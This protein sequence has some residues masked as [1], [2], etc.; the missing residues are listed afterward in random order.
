MARGMGVV[1]VPHAVLA[2]ALRV[3]RA[4]DVVG[5]RGVLLPL[6]QIDNSLSSRTARKAALD[7]NSCG[8]AGH[9]IDRLPAPIL[10]TV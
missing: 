2:G 7:S 1:G 4:R 6:L 9:E 8:S 3:V 5:V 10:V